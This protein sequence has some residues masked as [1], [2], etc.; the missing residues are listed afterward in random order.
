MK[1]TICALILTILL[2]GVLSPVAVYATEAVTEAATEV[3]TEAVTETMTET[4]TEAVAESVTEA[5]TEVAT[6][7]PAESCTQATTDIFTEN[8]TEASIEPSTEA[9]TKP[10]LS[11]VTE[12]ETERPPQASTEADTISPEL[13][14]ILESATPEQIENI[15]AYIM[16]GLNSLE[17]Y[18]IKGWD[19]VTAF[20]MAH[21]EP[22]A[23]IVAA[24]CFLVF[25]VG[26]ARNRRVF[27]QGADLMTSNAVE[28][29][30]QAQAFMET[31]EKNTEA[32]L[33]A[34]EERTAALTKE[35]KDLIETNSAEMHSL[36]QRETALS[37]AVALMASEI[38]GL[39]Q[40]S[41]LPEWKR[42]EL[43]S[44]FNAAQA[45][46]EEVMPH[47]DDKKQS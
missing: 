27:L 23:W 19:K 32:V 43:Q 45:K 24:I 34:S 35:V 30:E 2:C 39:L 17:K 12:A 40:V 47:E 5:M 1:K 6:Q 42:D 9:A 28:I 8:S 22:I 38:N 44:V 7:I 20:V 37:Q 41:N 15:K 33:A 26:N 31:S 10:I 36:K 21:L 4:M 18:D 29:A 13:K 16:A 46:V 14:E 11:F 25:F 3:V